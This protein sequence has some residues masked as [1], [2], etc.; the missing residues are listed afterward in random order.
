MFSGKSPFY[1]RWQMGLSQQISYGSES[2]FN[3][4]AF[5]SGRHCNC[6]S[7]DSCLK[8]DGQTDRQSSCAMDRG[9]CTEAYAAV[10]LQRV[11]MM[12]LYTGI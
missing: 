3:V 8:T 4:C 9:V 11:K 5:N 12:T 7:Q 10:C 6:S 1:F 2:W